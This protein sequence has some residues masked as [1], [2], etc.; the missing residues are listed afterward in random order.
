MVK[1]FI[2]KQHVKKNTNL[3]QKIENVQDEINKLKGI[4]NKLVS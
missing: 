2:A 3:Q 4:I 1:D